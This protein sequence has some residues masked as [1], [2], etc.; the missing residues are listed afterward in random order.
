MSVSSREE[1]GDYYRPL[2]PGRYTLVV[3]KPGFKTFMVNLTVPTDG[4]GAQR[5]FVL[6]REGSSGSGE[7]AYS[8]KNLSL[9]SSS[10]GG[11]GGAEGTPEAAAA[12]SSS[13]SSGALPWRKSRAAQHAGGGQAGAA[14]RDAQAVRSRDRLLMLVTGGIIVYGLWITHARLQRRTH[15][16]RA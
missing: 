1:L 14:A 3:S 7:V 5:H 2:A 15:Q 6:A 10:S 13:S 16:R 4:S 12:D 8:L 11:G 9:G